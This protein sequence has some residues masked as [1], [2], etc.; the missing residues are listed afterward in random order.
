[1]LQSIGTRL[2]HYVCLLGYDSASFTAQNSW[3]AE[4]GEA[5]RFRVG[6]AVIAESSDLYAY[7]LRMRP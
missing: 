1:M 5:G 2:D 7:D 6:D 3:G 4:W